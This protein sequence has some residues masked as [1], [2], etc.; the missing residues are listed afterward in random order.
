MF[1][2]ILVAHDGSKGAQKALEAAVEIAARSDAELHMI[3]V[4]ERLPRQ[5]Q[6]LSEIV[7]VQEIEGLY[8]EQVA[9]EAK[10]LAARRSVYLECTLVRGHRVKTI[11]QVADEG[12]FDL[13]VVGFSGHS[14]L[15]E[16]LWGRASRD[17][18]RSAPCNVLVVK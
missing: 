1:E 5:T 13:L 12:G 18:M 3:S 16:H 17:L 6:P 4:Q 2:K 14:R 11:V 9:E 7:D 10:R 8:F 15:N